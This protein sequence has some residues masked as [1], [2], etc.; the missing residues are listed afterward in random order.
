MVK[1]VTETKLDFV[2]YWKK[3]EQCFE[4]AKVEGK[5]SR[6][7]KKATNS[8]PRD[9]PQGQMQY[10]EWLKKVKD[11][12]TDEFYHQRDKDGNIIKGTGSTDVQTQR[13]GNRY[14]PN[15]YD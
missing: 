10:L 1:T 12:D 3:E 7:G 8:W 11:R 6:T 4:D 15:C 14:C 2:P 13:E 9:I 5:A